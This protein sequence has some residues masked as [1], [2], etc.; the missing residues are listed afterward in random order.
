M[1]QTL[2]K[3]KLTNYAAQV[4]GGQP[5]FYYPAVVD[6][7]KNLHGFDCI[8]PEGRVEV[9]ER[10]SPRE[11]IWSTD[12]GG[13]LR[14]FKDLSDAEQVKVRSKVNN[15]IEM[16]HREAR[17]LKDD[18]SKSKR[19]LGQVLEKID[20]PPDDFIYML[21]GKPVIT[22][23]GLME[24]GPEPRMETTDMAYGPAK[25]PPIAPPMTPPKTDFA[26]RSPE[27]TRPE[28]KAPIPP[29]AGPVV[30][31]QPKSRWWMWALLALLLLL[32]L[33]A[34]LWYLL[35]PETPAPVKPPVQPPRA[36]T[37]LPKRQPPASKPE[38]PAGIQ[39]KG[40]ETSAKGTEI[41]ALPEAIEFT[42]EKTAAKTKV[43][44]K[45]TGVYYTVPE[46]TKWWKNNT[47][48]WDPTLKEWVWVG[49]YKIYDYPE[50]TP[51]KESIPSSGAIVQGDPRK[52]LQL[53]LSPPD[54]AA[55]W[56][57][58]VDPDSSAAVLKNPDKHIVF[59][60]PTRGLETVG[61]TVELSVSLAK[62]LKATVTARDSKGNTSA[63]PISVYG[64]EN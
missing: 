28:P 34:L 39:V 48:I 47:I 41:P 61:P 56:K 38:A 8:L 12:S 2:I 63:Y 64:S 3:Q 24:E 54:T 32:L 14:P 37:E 35:K 52:V 36:Q 22:G 45:T 10:S 59:I 57:V 44:D 25:P 42:E 7:V 50:V 5:L 49:P 31:E 15:A 21:D 55:V 33:A 60:S 30:R 9:G 4:Q 40:A 53:T 18:E 27:P 26:P 11:I 23:W 58:S 51:Y 46:E 62:P 1:N 13:D 6:Y 43:L 17:S 20:A 19:D 16:L 29:I